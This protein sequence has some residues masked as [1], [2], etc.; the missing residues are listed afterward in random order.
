MQLLL[1]TPVVLWAGWPFFERGWASLKTRNLN[2]FTLHRHGHRR[3][4]DLQHRRRRSRRTSSRRRMR[5]HDGAVA[6]YFEAAA[7]ITRSGARSARCWS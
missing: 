7:V 6:V 4:V 1:A 3:G 5:G 2:M